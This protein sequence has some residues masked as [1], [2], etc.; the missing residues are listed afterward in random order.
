MNV[1][2]CS[3]DKPFSISTKGMSHIKLKSE[4]Y[5]MDNPI[6]MFTNTAS[7]SKFKSNIFT[8]VLKNLVI[9]PLFAIDWSLSSSA[10]KLNR[11][12]S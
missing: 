12:Y 7:L 10:S 8:I 6:S 2:V 1:A 9:N 4:K 11:E 3:I 5:S